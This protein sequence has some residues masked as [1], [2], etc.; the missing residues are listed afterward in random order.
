V[1]LLTTAKADKL[2]K[3]ETIASVLSDVKAYLV[4]KGR[5]LGTVSNSATT[6]TLVIDRPVSK[7]IEITI[8]EKDSNGNF[9]WSE[10]ASDGGWGHMGGTG[11]LNTLDKVHQI[12]D[13]RLK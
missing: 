11:L 7:W 13:A 4:S 8:G 5:T 12:I 10:K 2:Q 1:V 6:L 9:L 3:P